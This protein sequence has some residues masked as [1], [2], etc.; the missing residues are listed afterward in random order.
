M[1]KAIDFLISKEPYFKT[2]V[3]T[4]GDPT[5]PSRPEGFQ[6]LVLLIL[7]QQVSLDSAKAA[8][9][10]LQSKVN[11]IDPENLALLSDEEYRSAGVSR[12]KTSYIKGLSNS[13]LMNE[14][15]L[16]SL[17]HKS[18]EVVRQELIKLKGIGNWTIDV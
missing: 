9:K 3:E 14:I 8:F 1:K 4:Y 5:I 2:I 12:Q 6:T 17:K 16:E 11:S 10:K 15:D 13:I 18:S 7:E